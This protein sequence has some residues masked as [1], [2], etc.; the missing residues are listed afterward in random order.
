M[1]DNLGMVANSQRLLGAVVIE[2]RQGGLSLP[3]LVG[4]IGVPVAL[5]GVHI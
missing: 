1:V 4:R 3:M 5:R 2:F